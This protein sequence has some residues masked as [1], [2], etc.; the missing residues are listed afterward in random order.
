M[1]MITGLHILGQPPE[2]EQFVE[3][4]FALTKLENGAVPSL[5]KTLATCMTMSIIRCWKQ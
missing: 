2:E 5:P 3:Y 4:L 1:Q